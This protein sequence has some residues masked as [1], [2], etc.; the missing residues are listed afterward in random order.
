MKKTTGG[1][2]E[3]LSEDRLSIPDKFVALYAETKAMGA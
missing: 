2:V 3:G 1:D